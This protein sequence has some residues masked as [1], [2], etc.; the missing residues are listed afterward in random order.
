MPIFEY[1][2]ENCGKTNEFLIIG[3]QEKL[4]CHH[5]GGED[6]TKMMSAHNTSSAS[7]GRLAEKGPG[8]CCG[9]PNSCDTPGGCCSR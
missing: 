5:C 2:C 4:Y 3:K 8:S 9:S 6:L 1:H 7:P